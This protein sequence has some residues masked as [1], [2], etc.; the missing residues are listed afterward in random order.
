MDCEAFEDGYIAA[1]LTKA[2]ESAPVGSIVAVMAKSQADIPAVQ[3][4]V[5]IRVFMPSRVPHQL[6]SFPDLKTL[7]GAPILPHGVLR[8][9]ATF[10]TP[11]RL[12]RGAKAPDL[13]SCRAML[14]S[15]SFPGCC[16]RRCYCRPCRRCPR[17]GARRLGRSGG[18][19]VEAL[20]RVRRGVHAR[21]LE[22]HDR[23]QDRVVV[24]QAGREGEGGRRA[25]GR[26]VRQGE[27]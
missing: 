27:T 5:S 6:M 16:R 18:R 7:L 24:G 26:R 8:G 4:R 21:A 10:L 22:H 1:I 13:L 23:G 9:P 19:C 25:H 2:G 3:V 20:V 17:A 12:V 11:Q 14:L 15:P